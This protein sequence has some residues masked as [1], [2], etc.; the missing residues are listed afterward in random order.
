M[1]ELDVRDKYTKIAAALSNAL[2]YS[3][4][5]ITADDSM[6]AYSISE[7]VFTISI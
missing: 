7:G 6:K 4:I 1:A 5:I 2:E 3:A